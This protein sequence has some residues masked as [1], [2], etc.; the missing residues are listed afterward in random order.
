MGNL[1]NRFP[2]E[3]RDD[4]I[5]RALQPG[6]VLY[7]FCEFT[8]PPKHKY[9]VLLHRDQRPL[10]FVIN[11]RVNAYILHRPWLAQSQVLIPAAS[12]SFLDHDSIIDCSN[13]RADMSLE[14]MRNQLAP[15]LTLYRGD[16]DEAVRR[17]IVRVVDAATTISPLHKQLIRTALQP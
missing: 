12:H 5:D 7:L 14:D 9:L 17:E 1:G 3:L 11:S 2:P 6:S 16:L 4:A 15:N 8:T 13:V 10:F